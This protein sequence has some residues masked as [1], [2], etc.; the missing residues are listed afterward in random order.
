MKP[1]QLI[2]EYDKL[3]LQEIKQLMQETEESYYYV[4]I[5]QREDIEKL[6]ADKK[7]LRNAVRGKL[8]DLLEYLNK[9]KFW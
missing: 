8:K 9:G 4:D 3:L 1:E 6:K 7:E 2:K 5:P